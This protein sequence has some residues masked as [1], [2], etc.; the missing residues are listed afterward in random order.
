MVSKQLLEEIRSRLSI[1]GFVGEYVPLK[2]SG[3]NF[4]GLCPFHQEKSPSFMV[5][6]EKQIFHCFGCGFGGDIF[7]FL[8]KFNG[9]TLPEA[10]KELAKKANVKL[11]EFSKETAKE[12]EE[13]AKK[14]KVAFR[15]NEIAKDT[16]VKNL[17]DKQK[18]KEALHYL[19]SRGL[20]K[21]TIT[22]NGLGYTD[23]SWDGLYNSLMAL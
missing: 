7:T 6:E 3:R 10:L 16:F 19:E 17:S 11:P 9:L 21:K 1:A 12:D 15:I 2:R 8:M 5:T 14:K 18:G 22:E 4:K 20:N 23:A 13:W